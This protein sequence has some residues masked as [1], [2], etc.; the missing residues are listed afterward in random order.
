MD[1]RLA[2]VVATTTRHVSQLHRGSARD[3]R[4]DALGRAQ[5]AQPVQLAAQRVGVD[6]KRAPQLLEHAGRQREIAIDAQDIDQ[7]P[8]KEPLLF[9]TEHGAS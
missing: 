6:D 3:K 1:I 8:Q 2:A 5:L 9:E 4:P 7:K